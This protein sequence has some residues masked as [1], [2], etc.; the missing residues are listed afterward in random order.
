MFIIG[1]TLEMIINIY[2]Y[3]NKSQ[4]SQIFFVIFK[5]RFLFFFPLFFS[6]SF[7]SALKWNEKLMPLPSRGL[8]EQKD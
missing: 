3:Y 1:N 8:K 6:S 4:K 2:R 5:L 7:R